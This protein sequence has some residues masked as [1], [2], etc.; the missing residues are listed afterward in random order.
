MECGAGFTYGAD[1]NL[2]GPEAIRYTLQTAAEHGITVVRTFGHG[3]D[4]YNSIVLQP[5]AGRILTQNLF[6]EHL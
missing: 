4:A 2:T 5:R 6:A 3:H 1:T